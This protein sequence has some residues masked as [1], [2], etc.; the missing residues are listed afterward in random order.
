V[1]EVDHL[2]VVAA[3]LAQGAAWCERVLGV[4]PGGGGRH[5]L[6]GTHNRL[7]RVAAEPAY[8]R[9][10]LEVIAVDP[11]ASPPARA[12]WFGMDDPALQ[13]AVAV[14]PRLVAWACG[15]AML[16]MHRWGLV[17]AGLAP[18]E[19][20]GASRETPH[21]RLQWRIALRDDGQPGC[22]GALPALI[23]WQGSAHPSGMLPASGVR[24]HGLALRGLPP[25]AAAVLA[26]R[27]VTQAL[28]E[29][30]PLAATFET[31][32]GRVELQGWTR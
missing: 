11:D 12:R 6:M 28:G 2:V 10:Y 18:G 15:T 27:G 24:L 1:T 29:A 20:V 23:E 13:A 7:L 5:P 30:P 4:A 9:A 22:G 31:P 3:D 26:T 14:E 25:Q 21:G 16:D 17:A 32:R 8:P 19:P